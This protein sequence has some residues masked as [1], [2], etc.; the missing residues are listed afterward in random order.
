M[1]KVAFYTLG[2][3]VNTYDTEALAE[4][5]EKEGY[6]IV[7]FHEKAD[8]YVINTCTVTNLGD[9]K[10]RQM[11][12]K[13]KKINTDAI[14]VVAGCYAQTAPEELI[15]IPEVNLVIGNKDR[16]NIVGLVE[17]ILERKKDKIN[18]VSNIM[19]EA[20]FEELSVHEMKGKTRA[21]IKIQEGC[22]QF[23]SYCII[24]YA[25]GPIRSRKPESVLK[26][27]K[28]L[29]ESDYNEVV[30]TGIHVASYGKDLGQ[31]SLL[32]LMQEIHKIEEIQRI[33]LSSLEPRLLTEDFLKSLSELDKFCPHFHISLQSGSDRILK[34]MKRKYTTAEYKQYVKNV[35]KYFPLAS[36]TT[37]IMV[38][39]P[40]EG[41][42]EFQET[43]HFAKEIAFSKIH[44]FKYSSRKGTPAAKYP[45]QVK[46]EIKEERSKKLI[47]LA[48]KME[49]EYY[50]QFIGTT[51]KILFEQEVPSRN[52]YYEGLTDNYIRVF[53]KSSEDIKGQIKF[54]LLQKIWKDHVEGK[55]I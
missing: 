4:I 21:F 52:G 41:E 1:K 28:K 17:K 11:I 19:K 25:R 36:I 51:K 35:R 42:E 34:A 29:A 6:T 53:A 15:K 14:I 12:R 33:R 2:C 7:N 48:E 16:K 39:F 40:G 46:G 37:D 45:N 44:V 55:L 47:A 38:G 26:E 3:K 31:G 50:K 49:R 24:P 8:V 43:Y 13:A 30:L 10:S 20:D 18:A 9:R 23:C 27:V 32:Q 22:N 5:F 54:I